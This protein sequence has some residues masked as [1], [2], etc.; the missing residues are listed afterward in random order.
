[1]LLNFSSA[2]G[3]RRLKFVTVL[4]R[5]GDRSPVNVYPTDPNKESA[6]PQGLG[7]LTQDGMRQQFELGQ[8]LQR[9]YQ[10][11]LNET[12]DRHQI[13]VHSTDYDRTLMSAEANLAGMYP[14][15]GSQVF[16]PNL[17]WQPIPVHTVPLDE[18]KITVH[19]TD[20][21]R[22]LMSAEA[23]LAGMYPPTGSQVF[24]PNLN[25][26]PIPVHTVPLDEDKLLEVPLS[27]C[28]LYDHLLEETRHTE[29]YL[30]TAQFY[31]VVASSQMEFLEMLQN[32][33]GLKNITLDSAWSLY[34][35]LLCEATHKMPQPSW[36]NQEVMETLEK[37]NDFS[38]QILF[39]LYKKI[40]KSRVQGGV[41]LGQILKN[42]TQFAVPIDRKL[43]MMVYSAHDTTII[44]LQSALYLFNGRQPPY[45]S[46]HIFELLQEDDGSFSVAMYFR[47]DTTKDPYPLVLRN[48]TQYCPLQ[49][50]VRHTKPVIP[51]NWEEECQ[52]VNQYEKVQTIALA[53]G[54]FLLGTILL[55]VLLCWLCNRRHN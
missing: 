33:T 31:K 12:Y 4:Y 41:L 16:N 7:Q 2:V 53:V 43:K 18:D 22:T 49:D 6:W 55:L 28:P 52:V 15:T 36:V 23:N 42:I 51:E 20:Y 46:C 34:D 3:E 13:T 1:M 24:N 30:N 11:F 9:R 39:G 50:F 14:P 29:V 35:T 10:G 45:A 40:E 54:G 37:I 17:N 8:A 38:Y 47:N 27:P 26:Q 25:W 5:H 19:S 44:A 48:C 21:D 32:K